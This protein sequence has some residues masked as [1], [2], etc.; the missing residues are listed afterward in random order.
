MAG[1]SP[2]QA[3]GAALVVAQARMACEEKPRAQESQLSHY[4][5]HGPQ[6]LSHTMAC[7]FPDHSLTCGGAW[8]NAGPDTGLH[9]FGS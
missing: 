9:G 6:A 1:V 3:E 5:A 4:L 7:L 8:G 2:D